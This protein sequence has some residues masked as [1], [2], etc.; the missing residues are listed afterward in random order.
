AALAARTAGR[1]SDDVDP[2]RTDPAREDT[3]IRPRPLLPTRTPSPLREPSRAV[4][5]DVTRG[6][7]LVSGSSALA[8][9]LSRAGLA[10]LPEADE[11][12]R[13]APDLVLDAD[14]GPDDDTA[15]WRATTTVIDQQAGPVVEP[16]IGP[17]LAAAREALGL[18][19]GQL[20][21]R[22]RIR[23]HVIDAVEIDDFTPCGGDFYARGHLRTLARVL[24]LDAA[25]LLAT[26]DERY[27]VAPLDTRRV[28]E[29][30]LSTGAGGSIRSLRGGPNWSVIVAAVM[31]V[32]LAWSIARLVVDQPQD[33]ATD[34]PSLSS[35]S[36]GLTS[37]ST[38]LAP[39]VPVALTA[40]GGG[41]KVVVRDGAGTVVFKGDLAF[42][43]ARTIK[44]SPPVRV[45]TSDGS[46]TVGIDGQDAEPMGRAGRAAR[47]T[48]VP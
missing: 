27:A 13:Q 25:P 22:T 20:A 41:A 35:G 30:E 1:G 36:A 6:R 5:S 42:G 31:A 21:E 33:S 2:D 38:T 48:F 12:H 47:D 10:A 7:E 34:G 8:P 9:D 44:A 32:V 24:N 39:A 15:G 37:G 23:A 3:T 18:G 17:Q 46:L 29:A 4:R 40:A 26:Y 28:F 11:L 19:V 45:Q 16:V 14:H 43:Q